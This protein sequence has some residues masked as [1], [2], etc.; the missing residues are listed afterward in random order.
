MGGLGSLWDAGPALGWD[1]VGCGIMRYRSLTLCFH[2]CGVCLGLEAREGLALPPSSPGRACS[3][4]LS[5]QALYPC[6]AGWVLLS[7]A[8]TADKGQV[9]TL[10]GDWGGLSGPGMESLDTEPYIAQP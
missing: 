8:Q 2:T 7:S 5:P 4:W 9:R 10:W 1:M 3:P 6:P